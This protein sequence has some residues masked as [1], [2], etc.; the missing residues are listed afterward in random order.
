MTE[1]KNTFKFKYGDSE[2]TFSGDFDSGNLNWAGINPE[3]NVNILP[4]SGNTAAVRQG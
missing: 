2:L 3:T 1:K 4:H